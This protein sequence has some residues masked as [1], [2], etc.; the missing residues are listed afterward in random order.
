MGKINLNGVNL[1]LDL[2]DIDVMG[3]YEQLMNETVERVK[4]ES[5]YEGKSNA[6][7]MKYQC[8]LV[9]DFFDKLFGEGTAEKVFSGKENNLYAHLEAFATVAKAGAAAKQKID[10][11]AAPFMVN[12]NRAQRRAEKK[13]KKTGKK[14]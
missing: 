5:Q 11:L 1:E 12:Q 9:K 7:G 13:K 14:K 2:M 4:D 8:S 10:A 6:E 3:N